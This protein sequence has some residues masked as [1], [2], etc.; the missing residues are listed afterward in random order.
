MTLKILLPIVSHWVTIF[1]SKDT[2]TLLYA[3]SFS[4]YSLS[5]IGS[6]NI[7]SPKCCFFLVMGNWG[8][9]R[10]VNSHKRSLQQ[11]W[12][13]LLI[14]SF[15]QLG[16]VDLFNFIPTGHK[17]CIYIFKGNITTNQFSTEVALHCSIKLDFKT[18]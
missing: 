17:Q 5:R 12:S 6:F 2:K 3:L 1:S 14:S 7:S 16:N 13:L 18:T 11:N 9:N 4:F 10:L 8:I 15:L